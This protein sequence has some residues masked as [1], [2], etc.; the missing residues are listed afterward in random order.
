MYCPI[1]K[2]S[3]DKAGDKKGYSRKVKVWGRVQGDMTMH[4]SHWN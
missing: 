3:N 2:E 1:V 4:K